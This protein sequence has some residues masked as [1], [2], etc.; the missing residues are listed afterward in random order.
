MVAQE[1]PI[2][3]GGHD[4]LRNLHAFMGLGMR[5]QFDPQTGGTFAHQGDIAIEDVDVDEE[6]WRGNIGPTHR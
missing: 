4:P 2:A 6:R 5:A 3:P 1:I